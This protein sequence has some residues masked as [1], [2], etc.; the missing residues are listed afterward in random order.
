MQNKIVKLL[1]KPIIEVSSSV[2][3]QKEMEGPLSN[4]FDSSSQ[5]ERFGMETF[6]QAES[7]M[8]K[9]A[10]EISL[11]NQDLKQEI[12]MAQWQV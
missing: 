10:F 11:K 9:M 1:S 8:V 6:E 12:S 4:Y 5:D 3:G 7:E 2:V